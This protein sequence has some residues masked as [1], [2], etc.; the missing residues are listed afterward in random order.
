[1]SKVVYIDAGHGKYTPGKR[2]PSG[3][4]EEREWFFNDEVAKAFKKELESYKGV[5][6]VRVDDVTGKRD[7]PLGERT[8]AANKAKA[9]L[10]LSFHHNAYQSKWGN[11]GGT[12]TFYHAGSATGKKLA[13][14]VQD[15]AMKA[16]GLTD[17]GIKTANLHITR[18][19]SMPAVLLEGG[20]MDSN[21]DIKKLRDK[22][23][24]QEAGRLVAEAVAKFL[25]LSKGSGQKPV[26]PPKTDEKPTKKSNAT[27]AKEVIAGK[28]GDGATRKKR[29]TDAGYNYS[30]IQSLVNKQLGS[31]ST[32]KPKPTPS[33]PKEVKVGSK[34]KIK[35]G[36]K[37]Y[38][39]TSTAIP[40]KWKNKNLTVQQVG[41]DDVLIKEVYSWVKKSDLV[42]GTSTTSSNTS[43][44]KPKTIKKGSKVTIKNSAKFYAT[45]QSIPSKYKGKSFTVQQVGKN[46]YLLKELYSWVKKSDVQ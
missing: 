45:G 17:R 32:S 34:V 12:E 35:S 16:Y 15:A 14:A 44:P 41:K 22:K 10:Y 36:A 42:G 4:M 6:V 13:Q 39:R 37:N 20:F 3:I 2:S 26:E 1:M 29:L 40:A 9:D 19:T 46:K 5:K 38:S 8:G 11:H 18:E 30:T 27:I 7:V 24:L 28:W 21:V 33:K 25:G 31:G 23:V 43:K